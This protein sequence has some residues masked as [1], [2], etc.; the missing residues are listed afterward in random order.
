MVVAACPSMRW[1]NKVFPDLS[2]N[3]ALTALWQQIIS[4]CRIDCDDPVAAWAEHDA[5]LKAY[6]RWLNEQDFERLHYE[7]HARFSC[8]SGRSA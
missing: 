4:I 8:S 1:A 5:R 6:E 3:D 2:D 7:D